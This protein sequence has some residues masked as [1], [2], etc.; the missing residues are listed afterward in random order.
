MDNKIKN[1]IFKNTGL[2]KEAEQ[3]NGLPDNKFD[4]DSLDLSF[5]IGHDAD[6][7]ETSNNDSKHDSGSSNN[8]TD[9]LSKR[10]KMFELTKPQVEIAKQTVISVNDAF[11]NIKTKKYND[12]LTQLKNFEKQL[13]GAC[14]QIIAEVESIKFDT[15]NN[16]QC[17]PKAY[18]IIK[19]YDSRDRSV[20]ELISAIIIF[21]NSLS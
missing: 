15:S 11:S 13:R 12:M 14:Q 9:E 3:E 10:A 6:R 8:S 18:S 2:L 7:K 5:D 21:H 17:S 20:L 1:R 4:G 19:E 16:M